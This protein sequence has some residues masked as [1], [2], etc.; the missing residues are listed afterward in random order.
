[1]S[2]KYGWI[3]A[4]SHIFMRGTNMKKVGVII[5]EAQNWTIPQLKKTITRI[6]DDCHVVVIGHTGQIDL[7]KS[8]DSGFAKTIEHFSVGLPLEHARDVGICEL[9]KNFRGWLSTHADSIGGIDLTDSLWV[10]AKE[11]AYSRGRSDDW[12]YV[13]TVYNSLGGK[14]MGLL[15]Y[16]NGER[17]EVISE[18]DS[19]SVLVSTPDGKELT[20]D[21]SIYTRARKKFF[22]RGLTKRG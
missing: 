2:D 15:I 3:V 16:V 22:K 14:E 8:S 9:S 6:H 18:I 12:V 10:R 19:D 21:K 17:Y 20:L 1:M 4:K 13:I 11:I 5:D 7:R